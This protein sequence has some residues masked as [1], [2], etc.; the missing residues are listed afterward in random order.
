MPR[1]IR[2]VFPRRPSRFARPA[3]YHLRTLPN[4]ETTIVSAAPLR[5]IVIVVFEAP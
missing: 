2:S 3:Q 4:L 5:R 1:A